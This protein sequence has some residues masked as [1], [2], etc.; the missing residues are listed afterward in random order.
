MA[1]TSNW[2][3][4]SSR[5]RESAGGGLGSGLS[6]KSTRKISVTSCCRGCGRRLAKGQGASRAIGL[7]ITTPSPLGSDEYILVVDPS[8]PCWAVGN[9]SR[10]RSVSLVGNRG[11]LSRAQIPQPPRRC[12]SHALHPYYCLPGHRGRREDGRRLMCH[13]GENL[14]PSRLL[15]PLNICCTLI[16]T[17]KKSTVITRRGDLSAL[18]MEGRRSL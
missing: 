1:T 12:L 9:T 8:N 16:D 6:A 2:S 10:R 13:R 17:C 18:G 14:L 4:S 11:R 7:R 5:G 15:H 3:G